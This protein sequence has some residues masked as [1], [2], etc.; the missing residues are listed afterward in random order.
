MKTRDGCMTM[1]GMMNGLTKGSTQVY[2][3]T[4]KTNHKD[5]TQLEEEDMEQTRL[6]QNRR[7][8]GLTRQVWQ[9]TGGKTHKDRK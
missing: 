7:T 4:R 6:T 8:T 5:E 3:H 9:K 1:A 2:I